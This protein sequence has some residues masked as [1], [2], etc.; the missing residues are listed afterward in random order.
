MSTPIFDHAQPKI[1]NL[2]LIF[3]NLYQDAKHAAV[4]STCYGEIVRLKILQSD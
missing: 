3:I 4:S 2:F 1:L